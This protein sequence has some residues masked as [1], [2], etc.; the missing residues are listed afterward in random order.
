ML[1][2][3]FIDLYEIIQNT[4]WNV[5]AAWDYDASFAFCASPCVIAASYDSAA[6]FALCCMIMYLSIVKHVS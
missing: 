1:L 4:P 3:K 5:S 6:E 2:S